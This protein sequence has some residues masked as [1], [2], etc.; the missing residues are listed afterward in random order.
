MIVDLSISPFSSLSSSCT[1]FYV[2]FLGPQ[3]FRLIIMPF[4]ENGT[5][6]HYVMH[7]PPDFPWFEACSI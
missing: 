5:V 1:Y 2:L 6:Y 7:F 3:T 4:L